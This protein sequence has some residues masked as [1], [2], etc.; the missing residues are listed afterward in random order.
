MPDLTALTINIWNRQG[1]WAERKKL[2]RAGIEAL[3]PDVVA[4]QEVIRRGD[5]SQAHELAEG[6]DYHVAFG[7]ARPL[8]AD[9]DYGNAILSRFPILRREVIA[10]P[11]CGVDEPRSVLLVEVGTQAGRLPLLVTHYS[12][13]M[14]H[15]FVREQQSLAIATLLDEVVSRGDDVLPAVLMGDLNASPDASEVRFLLGLQVVEGRSAYLA[16]CY[17][18]TGD[19]PGYTFDGRHN[20]FAAP[21]HERPRRIDYI[22]VRGPDAK[23]RGKPLASRVVFDQLIDGVAASDHY[24]VWARICM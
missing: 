17:G 16:D 5:S 15:G 6:L 1:P 10:I 13:R 24:G 3:D 14:E 22:L 23:G 21:W 18:E 12:Y 2:L 7:A 9:A 11:V 4:M 20:P 8:D 19:G